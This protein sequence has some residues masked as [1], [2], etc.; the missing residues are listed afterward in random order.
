MGPNIW[1]YIRVSRVC[2]SQ[3]PSRHSPT[4]T[5]SPS[6]NKPHRPVAPSPCAAAPP[7][8]VPNPSGARPPGPPAPLRSAS[9]SPAGTLPGG[10]GV[11]AASSS[12]STR[13][14]PGQ[15]IP[16]GRRP[17]ELQIPSGRRLPLR[18]PLQAPSGMR[19]PP[20]RRLIYSYML[21][22]FVCQY[23]IYSQIMPILDLF[24]LLSLV[25]TDLLCDALHVHQRRTSIDRSCSFRLC[26]F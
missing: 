6:R 10:L 22:L 21:D 25:V 11:S 17:A 9:P 24:L 19:S 20:G 1:V 4:P 26:R 15:Q 5:P 13:R 8:Q 2:C 12:P 3:A 7:T 14:L 16:S 18:P 23:K